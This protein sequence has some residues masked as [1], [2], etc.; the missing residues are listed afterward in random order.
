M[1][2][3]FSQKLIRGVISS[4]GF[5]LFSKGLA[6][7]LS[8]VLFRSLS[9]HEYG[10][11]QLIIA[12]W[13]ILMVFLFQGL[14]SLVTSRASKLRSLDQPEESRQLVAGFFTLLAGVCLFLFLFVNIYYAQSK[15]AADSSVATSLRLLSFTLLVNPFGQLTRF[16]FSFDHEFI[17]MNALTSC[18]DA[19]K[20][21]GVLICFFV[22]DQKTAT[23][24]IASIVGA[25]FLVN[26]C[27]FPLAAKRFFQMFKSISWHACML[28]IYLLK[29]EGVW[30][31]LQKQIRQVGQNGRVFLVELLL[32]REVLALYSFAE[33]ITTQVMA[34]LPLDDVLIPLMSAE[35]K[36]QDR[37]KRV[38]R[39]G[40]KYA[41]WA[42]SLLAL[43]LFFGAPF[44][45]PFFFPRYIQAI[46]SVQIFALYVPFTGM[47]IL[48]SS[49]FVSHQ[50]Q[51]RL[52]ILVLARWI[53]FI[54]LGYVLMHF[55]GV[56]GIALEYVISL[57]AFNLLRYR[58]LTK[59]HSWL[60]L[61][62]TELFK[63]TAEDRGLFKQ[64]IVAR[65]KKI[66]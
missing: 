57:I 31:V 15:G 4:T 3:S 16:F 51:K 10:T 55:F 7:L 5:S 19:L 59:L 53:W 13:G 50:S 41:T 48:L 8:L 37:V 28:V 12:A 45:V 58:A 26:I 65:F 35:V 42:F 9:L 38:F 60:A 30:A 18:E 22:L 27:F 47:A 64:F 11:Y 14:S 1:P 20:T 25:S 52:F 40:F 46:S 23:A 49:F 29:D 62:W 36:N 6:F 24:V 56:L 39:L 32:G 21:I 54:P 66:S 17:W 43:A 61:D 63:I 44:F 33:K 2:K 34:L